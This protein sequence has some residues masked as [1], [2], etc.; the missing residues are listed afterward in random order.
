MP[1]SKKRVITIGETRQFVFCPASAIVGG[2]MMKYK[3]D[4]IIVILATI[5]GIT[6]YI[7]N[8]R[9]LSNIFIAITGTEKLEKMMEDHLAHP[10]IKDHP[11]IKIHMGWPYVI[12]NMLSLSIF[13]YLYGFIIRRQKV[14]KKWLI[15][16]VPPTIAAF[17]VGDLFFLPIYLLSCLFGTFPS[18]R[19]S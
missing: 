16:L 15:C 8:A 13:W 10:N 12:F 18:S 19:K 11:N 17:A 4:A 7:A 3:H 9:I 14:T 5:I 1:E 6:I 2:D